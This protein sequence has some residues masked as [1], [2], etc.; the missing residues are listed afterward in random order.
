MG[1]DQRFVAGAGASEI[2]LAR[3]LKAFGEKRSGLEQVRAG[4]NA[5]GPCAPRSELMIW[6]AQYSIKAFA[7][8]L[9]VVPRT[10]AENA[11][12]DALQVKANLYAAHEKGD[13]KTGVDITGVRTGSGIK[14]SEGSPLS[15]F[16]V[17][18]T[19]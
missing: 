11:G 13:T 2:E 7:E 1:R 16:G 4:C 8:S 3:L 12:L 9:E 19:M 14:V 5:A 6:A 18:L 17:S 15:L 10:L